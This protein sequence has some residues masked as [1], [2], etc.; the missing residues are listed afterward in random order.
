[1]QKTLTLVII[2]WVCTA[3]AVPEGPEPQPHQVKRMPWHSDTKANAVPE[4][5]EPHYARR[6]PW[7][8]ATDMEPM[9]NETRALLNET[10]HVLV[11]ERDVCWWYS[12]WYL[13]LPGIIID[14]VK[15]IM[16]HRHVW[17]VSSVCMVINIDAVLTLVAIVIGLIIL[18]GWIDLSIAVVSRARRLLG[19]GGAKEE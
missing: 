12:E 7:P 10:L 9:D 4:S 8:N 6:M 16:G 17:M 18:L 3:S 1:M 2:L 15:M 5:P 19:C 14:V 13:V 11:G